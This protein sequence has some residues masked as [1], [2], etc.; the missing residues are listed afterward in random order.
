MW[1]RSPLLVLFSDS[2]GV[3]FAVGIESSLPPRAVRLLLQRLSLTLCTSISRIHGYLRVR[4]G[5]IK[6]S[7]VLRSWRSSRLK[8]ALN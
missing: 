7:V 1:L 3:G 2:L 8:P 5:P 4:C 6:S